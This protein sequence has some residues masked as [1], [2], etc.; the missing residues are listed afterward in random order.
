VHVEITLPDA[1]GR[2][3][4]YDIYLNTVR[5]Q[6]LL[7]EKRINLDR[8]VKLTEKFSGS[9]IE[10]HVRIAITEVLLDRQEQSMSEQETN[11]KSDKILLLDDGYMEK[12]LAMV[13]ESFPTSGFGEMSD[14]ARNMYL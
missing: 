6:N 11:V 4:I 13:K 8:W 2:K 1:K 14:S 5:Q 9:Q 12:A 10:E 3:E 7:D